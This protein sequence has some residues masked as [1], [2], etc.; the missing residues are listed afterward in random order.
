VLAPPTDN[1]LLAAPSCL[2]TSVAVQG[3]TLISDGLVVTLDR[4]QP[5][6][7]SFVV[8]TAMADLYRFQLLEVGGDATATSLTIRFES[9]GLQPSWSVPSEIFQ[10]G[11][12]YLVR[13][14]CSLGG[15]PRVAEGDL[16]ARSI[17]IHSAAVDSGVFTVAQ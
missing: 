9:V 6:N 15:T 12:T 4:K 2:P 14:S 8:D 10:G 13:A 17:P 5:V 3:A 1:T 16:S 11:K 7:V